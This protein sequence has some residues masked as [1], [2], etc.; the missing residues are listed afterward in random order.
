MTLL[1]AL[2][3]SLR[4]D[5]EVI[6]N[7]I[8]LSVS[9]DDKS[10]E[11]FFSFDSSG[12]IKFDQKDAPK[13]VPLIKSSKLSAM[14]IS[15]GLTYKINNLPSYYDSTMIFPLQVLSLELDSLE[16][17]IGIQDTLTLN[18][19]QTNLPFGMYFNIYDSVMDIEYDF[20]HIQN[21]SIITDSLGIVN[22][23]ES[24]PLNRYLDYGDHRYFVSISFLNLNTNFNNIYPKFISIISK[25]SKPIQS[26]YYN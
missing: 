19:D 14:I 11:L 7:S 22:Y 10:D 5:N 18:I 26:N 21:I 13:L 6:N 8:K 15:E 3:V 24:G 17:L 9:K 25:L 2:L 23:E 1:L 12:S 16:N 20:N 4:T